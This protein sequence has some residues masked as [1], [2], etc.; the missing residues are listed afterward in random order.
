M[1]GW[2]LAVDIGT[3]SVTAAVSAGAVQRQWS[4]TAS[5]HCRLR[6]RAPRSGR[7]P[8]AGWQRRK[9][10]R[11][12]AASFFPQARPSGNRRG[13]CRRPWVPLAKL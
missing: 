13:R 6:S 3:T 5:G 2:T 11:N 7:L 8:P 1:A 9:H 10:M 12:P 4:S